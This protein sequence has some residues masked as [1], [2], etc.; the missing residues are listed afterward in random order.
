MF[1]RLY[2]LHKYFQ[3]VNIIYYK[4]LCQDSHKIFEQI[5]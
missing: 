5:V 4:N 2:G 1:V 3:T